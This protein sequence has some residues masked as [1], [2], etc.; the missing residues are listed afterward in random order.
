MSFKSGGQ[1]SCRGE[2][3]GDVEE[4][5]QLSAP[6]YQNELKGSLFTVLSPDL[7]VFRISSQ[8]RGSLFG[9]NWTSVNH[10]LPFV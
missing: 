3:G 2:V 5:E 6:L 1:G 4:L 10:T 8:G 7:S 9:P